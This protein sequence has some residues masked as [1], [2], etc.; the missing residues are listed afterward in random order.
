MHPQRLKQVQWPTAEYE[1]M[2]H[3]YLTMCFIAGLQATVMAVVIHILYKWYFIVHRLAISQTYMCVCVMYL[4]LR[5]Y[6]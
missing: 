2:P 3:Y 4:T 1:K 5:G 6:S